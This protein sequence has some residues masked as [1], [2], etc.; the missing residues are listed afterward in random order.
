MTEDNGIYTDI[1]NAYL[2]LG[3]TLLALAAYQQASQDPPNLWLARTVAN[4]YIIDENY[5]QVIRI[6][7]TTLSNLAINPENS[8]PS[9]FQTFD[10]G[11]PQRILNAIVTLLYA[12]KQWIRK[13]MGKPS[14]KPP[15][16]LTN[17]RL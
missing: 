10:D 4:V 16:N 3:Q 6:F 14:P 11:G 5:T 1:G 9:M 7:K 2:G 13:M 8:R 17:Q 15:L 12:M